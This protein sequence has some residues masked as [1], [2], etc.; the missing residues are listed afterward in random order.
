[1]YSVNDSFF[2]LLG[3]AVKAG[4]CKAGTKAVLDSVRQGKAFAVFFVQDVGSDT[5]KKLTDSGAYYGVTPYQ[6]VCSKQRLGAAC[7]KADTACVSITQQ[8]L[9]EALLAKLRQTEGGN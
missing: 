8:G 1:M 4:A 5:A 7:G 9:A 3:I 2:G 6:L